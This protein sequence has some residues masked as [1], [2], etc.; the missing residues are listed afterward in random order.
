MRARA[1]QGISV[2]FPPVTGSPLGGRHAA[3]DA[4]GLRAVEDEEPR[5]GRVQALG[6]GRVLGRHDQRQAWFGRGLP[7]RGD[8]PS[9]RTRA[10][11]VR[12]GG[13]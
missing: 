7:Y 12:L 5:A 4:T 6:G 11:Y 8:R 13:G 9:R 1:A 10:L 3:A 2:A